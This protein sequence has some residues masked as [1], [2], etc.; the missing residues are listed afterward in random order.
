ME[1]EKG[2]DEGRRVGV[3]GVGGWEWQGRWV[4]VA[5]VGGWEWQG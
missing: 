3:A 5:G 2:R 4:G 1:G